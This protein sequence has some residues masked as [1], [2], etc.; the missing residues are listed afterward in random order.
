MSGKK[1][2]SVTGDNRMCKGGY[3]V[4]CWAPVYYRP[5]HAKQ[6]VP[7]HTMGPHI[8]SHGQCKPQSTPELWRSLKTTV[9]GAAN[10]RTGASSTVYILHEDNLIRIVK[11]N[12]TGCC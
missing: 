7:N 6:A 3:A 10:R 5:L 8:T 12:R 1:A 9:S 11:H 4:T 2:V